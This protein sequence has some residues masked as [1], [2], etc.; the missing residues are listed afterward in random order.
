MRERRG[1]G[2]WY[3]SAVAATGI[4]DREADGRIL[5]VIGDAMFFFW[6]VVGADMKSSMEWVCVDL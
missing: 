6:G 4:A 2:G 3:L 5:G 1:G